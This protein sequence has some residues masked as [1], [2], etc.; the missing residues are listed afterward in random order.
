MNNISEASRPA[1]TRAQFRVRRDR[2]A[3][4]RA[5]RSQLPRD[6]H[7]IWRS[8]SSRRDPIEILEESN[9]ERLPELIPLRYGRMLRSPFTFLRGSAAVMAYDLATTPNTGIRVQACGD[10]HLL[11]FGLFATPERNLVFDIND[12]DE[13]HPAPW[14]WDLK[15]LVASFVVAGRDNKLSEQDSLAAVIECVRSYREHLREYSRMGPLEVWYTRLDIADLIAMAPDAKARKLQ[16][17]YAV[18]PRRRVIEHFFPK[19]VGRVD[20]GNRLFDK[21]PVPFQL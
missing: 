17:G 7:A 18:K 4:G 16:E 20:G 15:R 3:D 12:F 8:P 13:T 14:E 21:R 9:Q 1:G 11:N 2:I 10:C 5:L 6:A 19:I